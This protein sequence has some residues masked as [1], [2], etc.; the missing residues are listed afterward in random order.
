MVRLTGGFGGVRGALAGLALSSVAIG[1]ASAP[2]H[3]PDTFPTPL[4]REQGDTRLWGTIGTPGAMTGHAGAAVTSGLAAF[5]GGSYV[6]LDNCSTCQQRV[7]R[8]GELGVGIFRPLESG[9]TRELYLG[10][11]LGRFKVSS[12]PRVAGFVGDTDPTTFIVTSGRYS[13]VFVQGNLGVPGRYVD[14]AASFR[15]STYRYEDFEKRDGNG[16]LPMSARHWGLF[17]EP[18]LTLRLGLE[19]IKLESQLGGT[20]PLMQAEELDNRGF[21]LSVGVG[22]FVR[23]APVN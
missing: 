21:W 11:G 23:M 1:C 9:V 3:I 19:N 17:A 8:H 5:A 7:K 10:A 13:K 12:S 15:L 16:P 20:I 18:A 6:Q 4:F 14:R 2:G 22:L